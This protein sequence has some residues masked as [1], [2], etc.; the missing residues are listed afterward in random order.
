MLKYFRKMIKEKRGFTLMEL[1]AVIGI[2]SVVCA[3]AIPAIGSLSQTLNFKERNDYAK[4]IF[5]AAQANLSQMRSD[6]KLG[7][8]QSVDDNQIIYGPAP[9][10]NN[11]RFPS[12]IPGADEYMFVTNAAAEEFASILPVNSV[13]STAREQQVI[14]E[15]NP[16]TGNV[17]S[18]FCSKDS[19]IFAAYS[20]AEGLP[21]NGQDEE[22]ARKELQLGYYEGSGVGSET[23]TDAQATARVARK[24]TPDTFT[25]TVTVPV[26]A[27]YQLSPNA[28]KNGLSINLTII[29]ETE[30]SFVMSLMNKGSVVDK[31]YI[32]RDD[33][34]TG[35]GALVL[36]VTLDSVPEES[37][38][39]EE[40]PSFV[41]HLAGNYTQQPEELLGNPDNFKSIKPGDNI[42]IIVNAAFDPPGSDPD[43]V[44]KTE[45]TD[46]IG[47]VNPMF[48]SLS[49][50]NLPDDPTEYLIELAPETSSQHERHVQ[51]LQFLH[52][53]FDDALKQVKYDG[54]LWDQEEDPERNHFP[55][56]EEAPET[57]EPPVTG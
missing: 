44:F 49:L 5:L 11:S 48:E 3:I 28:F 1:L 40:H 35:Y 22:A 20:S 9:V 46:N 43:I 6:G 32:K 23:L 45:K 36:E 56:I 29:G 15:Y 4:S 51:N 2:I 8:L 41:N 30:G 14:I 39:D 50:L 12:T 33:A 54:F 16:Y 7:Q 52:K 13:E 21:R 53:D 57:D 17:Y 18:V 19:S 27:A 34:Y 37:G 38:Y 31:D 55:T 47:G 10:R 42:T 24:N 25:L 26:P